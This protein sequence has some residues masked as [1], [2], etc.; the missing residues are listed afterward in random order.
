MLIIAILYFQNEKRLYFDLIKSNMQNTVSKI[1]SKII[2]SHMSGNS[3]DKTNILNTNEYKIS[4]YNEEKEK[5]FG[6]LDDNIDFSKKI[7]THEKHFILIDDSTLGHLGI[8]YIAIEENLFH[9]KTKK[10]SLDIILFFLLIYSIISL[11]GYYLA[12]LFLEPIKK[13]REKINNF[14]KDTT[15]ELNTPISA[16]MMSTENNNLTEK[17]TERVRLSAIRISEIYKDLTYIF[18]EKGDE[19]KVTNDLRL[20]TVINEQLIYFKPLALKKRIH[21]NLEL[22]KFEYSINKDDFI[23]LLNNLISNAIKYNKMS[24]KIDIYLKDNELKVSDTGIGINKNKLK[25]IY[26]R[27]YRATSEQ[28]GFG[29]GLNIVN[30]VCNKNNISIKVDSKENE[31]TTFTLTF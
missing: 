24:G 23:R 8:Y 1:S 14:I 27:Y 13:E 21:I 11:I 26:K 31:G 30:H 10:L 22:E 6:N 18:L 20:D 4:F 2:F 5:I 7:M 9:K 15:H 25:D 17:Q 29:I 28:G 3:F 16:I 12:K 19:R